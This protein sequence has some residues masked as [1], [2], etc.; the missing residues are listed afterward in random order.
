MSLLEIEADTVGCFP[1]RELL[2]ANVTHNTMEAN[3]VK[4][5]FQLHLALLRLRTRAA[6]C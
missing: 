1:L 3:T 6:Q 5:E 2:I 4:F